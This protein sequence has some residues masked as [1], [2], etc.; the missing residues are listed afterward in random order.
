MPIFTAIYGGD[1]SKAW[2]TIPV[3]PALVAF[4]TGIVVYRVSDD[5]PKGNYVELK[6]HRQFPSVTAVS[7][8]RQGAGNWNSW[9]M[10]VQYACCFGVELT[11]NSAAAL[12]FA[13]MFGQSTEAAAAIAGVFGWFDLFARGLGGILSDWANSRWGMRG[14]LW[15]QTIGLLAE[16]IMI[17]VF[18][19]AKTL[20]GSLVALVIFSICVKATLGFNLAIV[21]YVDPRNMG[22]VIG[23]VNI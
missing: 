19:H 13:D 22:T 3:I 14:R 2:R 17:L 1:T 16:G 5:A 7:S 21:P 23:Y 20:A 10:F 6:R 12:Y 11:M 9:I 18:S 4:I 8:F 15:A